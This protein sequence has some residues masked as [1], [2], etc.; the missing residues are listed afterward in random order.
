MRT[1]IQTLKSRLNPPKKLAVN[2]PIHYELLPIQITPKK[3]LEMFRQDPNHWLQ[4][5]TRKI[6]RK[7]KFVDENNNEFKYIVRKGEPHFIPMLEK[8]PTLIEI[9]KE[10]KELAKLPKE[11]DFLD[12]RVRGVES[13]FNRILQLSNLPTTEEDT[14]LISESLYTQQQKDNQEKQEKRRLLKAEYQKQSLMQKLNSD[15][16]NTGLIPLKKST[17]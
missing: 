17:I 2:N 4:I 10:L 11:L 1:G 5:H 7:F 16:A 15:L 14:K 9:N 8:P 12:N 6:N 3:F 13:S